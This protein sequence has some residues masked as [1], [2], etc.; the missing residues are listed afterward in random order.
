M[1]SHRQLE[2]FRVL[3]DT[4]ALLEMIE[5]LKLQMSDFV[6]HIESFSSKDSR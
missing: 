2:H 6:T 3:H 4:R 5:D 1:Q